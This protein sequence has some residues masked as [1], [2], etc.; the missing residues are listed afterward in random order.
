MEFS[1]VIHM[2]V[3]SGVHG[4]IESQELPLNFDTRASEVGPR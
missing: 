3:S 1:P 2:A 4:Y